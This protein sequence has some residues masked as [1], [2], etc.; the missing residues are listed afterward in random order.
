MSYRKIPGIGRVKSIELKAMVE[1]AKRIEK[2]ELAR[3]E[4]IM[5]SQQVAR[6]IDVGY[7]GQA[8][9]ASGGYLLGYA[10]SCYSAEDGLYWWCSSFDC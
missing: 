5:S 6:R 4:Q 1:L 2:A 7:W 9:G 3:S 10:E 8:S